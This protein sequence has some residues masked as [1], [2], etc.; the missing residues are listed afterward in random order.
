MDQLSTISFSNTETA[1]SSKSTARLKKS[2]LL[3]RVVNRPLLAVVATSLVKIALF[4][5]LPFKWLIKKTVFEHFCGGETIEDSQDTIKELYKHNIKT[6]LDYSVEGEKSEEGFDQAV[7]ETLKTMSR[8][9][10]E[11]SMPF[12]VFK[13]SGLAPFGILV[14]VN[15]NEELNFKEKKLFERTIVRIDTICK[16]AFKSDVPILIDAEETYIQ[17]PIDDIVYELMKKYNG[18]KA[19]IYN[20]YQ[21]YRS[22]SVQRLA[23]A[24]D[25]AE[26]NGYFLGAK[27][28]R[29]AY[30]EQERARALH[31]GYPDPIHLN[32]EATD[33]AFND[34]LK[35]CIENIDHVYLFCGSHNEDSNLYLT[36]LMDEFNIKRED[37]R[38][39][40]AQ[41]YGM[42]DHISYN[43]AASRY[44]VAKYVPYG[45]VRYVM[46]YLFRRAEENTSVEGQSSRE[47]ILIKEE[48][49]RRKNIT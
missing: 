49:K 39:Y 1:F 5:R 17:K 28:V 41:L 10:E 34:G 42:G 24:I 25:E 2:L 43:L 14:K 47:L 33:K 31:L 37:H 12:C 45:P 40:F 9:K 23:A 27:L 44:Q 30:M 15:D 26:K 11:A 3:F 16:Q 6:I 20:T 38:V 35:L 32:K 19:I 36:E 22:D 18:Q 13:V 8:A 46:P 4:L 29:G 7:R 48:L 21:M